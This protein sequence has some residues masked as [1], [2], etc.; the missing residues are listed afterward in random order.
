MSTQEAQDS[1]ETYLGELEDAISVGDLVTLK[2]I[3]DRHSRPRGS[4]LR[5][6]VLADALV[7][8]CDQG[9]P[10]VAQYLLTIEN[11]KADSTSKNVRQG[12]NTPPLVLA[13][14]YCEASFHNQ[15]T[16]RASEDRHECQLEPAR[17]DQSPNGFRLL[18]L[19]LRH[20]V[21]ITGCGPDNDNALSHVVRAEVA[22]LLLAERGESERQ[23]ALVEK[24]DSDGN[25]ALMCAIVHSCCSEALALKYIEYGANKHTADKEGRTTLMNAAW[26]QHTQVVQLLLK[27]KSILER[28]DHK[29]RNIWHHIAS[30][31][32]RK[33]SDDMTKLLFAMGEADASVHATDKQGHTPLHWSAISGTIAIAKWLLDKKSIHLEAVEKQEGKT[34]LHFA[35]ANG[36]ADFVK[37][38]LEKGADRFIPCKD[39]LM[40]LHLAC[41]CTSDAVNAAEL[42]LRQGSRK[43]LESRTEEYMTP[44]HIAAAHGNEAIVNFILQAKHGTDVDACCEGGWTALHLA[45]GRHMSTKKDPNRKCSA[46]THDLLSR[47]EGATDSAPR[48]LAVVRA[49]LSANAKVNAKSRLSRTALHIAAEMGHVE[50]VKELLQQEGV[51]FAAK[52]SRGNTPLIDAAKSK[53]REQI[54]KLLAPWNDLFVQSL[55]PD[56]KQAAKLYDA[57]IIDFQR[58]PGSTILRHKISVSDVL[59]KE[60]GEAGA[61][62]H[63]HVS[64]RPDPKKDGAF[65]WIHLPANNLHWAHT[66]LTKHFIE[67]SVD[68]ES[69]RALER[70]LGQ[71]QHRG[72]RI[73]SKFMRPAC[74][75]LIGHAHH[76]S[77]HSR[78][79]TDESPIVGLKER[80]RISSTRVAEE[81]SAPPSPKG[82]TYSADRD[83]SGLRLKH[84]PQVTE[85]KSAPPS[86]KGYTYL[87]DRDFSGLQL[88][89]EPQV[90]EDPRTHEMTTKPL[91]L[92]IRAPPPIGNMNAVMESGQAS[93]AFPERKASPTTE[94]SSGAQEFGACLFMPYL[95]LENKENVKTMHDHLRDDPGRPSASKIRSRSTDSRSNAAE[96]SDRGR[97]AQLHKAYSQW[98]TND[99]C[100][101]VRRTLDQFWYRNVD[102]RVRDGDQVVQRYQ[103]KEDKPANMID[104]L[105]VDQLWIWVLGPSLIVTSFPQNWKHPRGERPGLLS[106]ILEEID[107]RNGTPAQ[108]AYELAACI[109]GHCLSSCDQT[110]E[111]PDQESI[112]RPSV[113]EMFGSSVGDVMNQE[114]I[115]FSHFN[116]ASFTASEWVKAM[117]DTKRDTEEALRELEKD[118]LQAIGKGDCPSTIAGEPK[119]VEDLLNIHTETKLLKEVKDIQD[120]LGILLQIVDDQQG[121][122]KDIRATF[123]PLLNVEGGPHRARSSGILEEQCVLLDQQRAEIE[124]ML[125][126]VKS[127]YKSIT[128]LLDL[129]QKQA[130][131]FEARAARKL[132]VE[133]ARAGGTLM[134]FTIVTVIFLPLSFLA[135]FFA[136]ILE[137]L[138]YNANDRLPLSFILKYVVG[139]GLC[140]ALAFVF[141]AWHH[142]SAARWLRRRF[143]WLMKIASPGGD[144]SSKPPH[145]SDH[146]LI[147]PASPSTARERRRKPR[148]L[149]D[150]D[151]LEKGKD[152][153]L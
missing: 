134:V 72:S 5:D 4:R 87:A 92:N 118:Y 135:A 152:S 145:E 138:P 96:S 37:A 144:S 67:G 30:D 110:I 132:A 15:L 78:S 7:I 51:Q 58:V 13:V 50:I 19:L 17:S 129:K 10:E 95:T 137:G 61:I 29:G 46:S 107:P 11:A 147:S 38:L 57:N 20:G 6:D 47:A 84:E 60:C 149:H 140:T 104:S 74:S 36:D 31:P 18:N 40:P 43:Q 143:K 100:L 83:F 112:S 126:Q 142:N 62:S 148:D 32:K 22:E 55:P 44:L 111:N 106:S 34:A 124:N 52:D 91:R 41:G 109:I 42:L 73:H 70:T 130:N 45:C 9:Y 56:V 116:E 59:Y 123:G 39:G 86:P 113:I 69:F 117:S 79:S 53:E 94:K 33:R 97:D 114:V 12:K 141:M 119:F 16:G 120:E 54:L 121:V 150:D 23:K 88:K 1:I 81:K 82:Y 125:K 146:T 151:D 122:H 89:L 108:S 102:T 136:I 25:D 3:I 139:V 76:P 85:E 153:P 77:A 80:G 63:S 8:S 127:T 14:K 71:Q 101:H 2:K 99:Y 24:R 27:E 48:Y 105:M 21:S 64:T 98:R 28:T 133:T 128:D 93:V 90:V 115:Q 65:R 66:L 131:V 75:R 35:A 103:K 26:R 68:V 49:L